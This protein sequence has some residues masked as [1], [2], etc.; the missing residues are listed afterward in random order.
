MLDSNENGGNVLS[1][2]KIMTGA[3]TAYSEKVKQSFLKYP[4]EKYDPTKSAK[5]QADVLPDGRL[6][7]RASLQN[8]QVVEHIIDQDQWRWC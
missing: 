2:V 1:Q 5:E 7:L 8:G 3:F 6:R 4:P